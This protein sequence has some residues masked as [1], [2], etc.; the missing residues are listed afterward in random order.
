MK[1]QQK[2]LQLRPQLQ[3]LLKYQ[4]YHNSQLKSPHLKKRLSQFLLRLLQLM[5]RYLLKFLLKL[6]QLTYHLRLLQL[7]YPLRHHQL[8]CPLKYLLNHLQLK[9]LLKLPQLTY[10]LRLLQLKYP[11]KLPKQKILQLTPPLNNKQ[12]L[13]TLNSQYPLKKVKLQWR[14]LMCQLVVLTTQKTSRALRLSKT[15]MAVKQ[16]HNFH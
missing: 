10:H 9:L 14:T 2:K 6:P 4:Q 16:S 13:L 3:S 1:H 11:L 12:L 8:R 5:L 15:Q 7:K